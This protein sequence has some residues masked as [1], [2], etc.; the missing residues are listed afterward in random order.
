MASSFI[1]MFCY[2]GKRGAMCTRFILGPTSFTHYY[3]EVQ[4]LLRKASQLGKAGKVSWSEVSM[5]FKPV[6]VMKKAM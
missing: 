1:S 3:G 5:T 4:L 2:K 6:Y